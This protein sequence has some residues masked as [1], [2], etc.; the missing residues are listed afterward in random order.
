METEHCLDALFRVTPCI[1]ATYALHA[2]TVSIV[3]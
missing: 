1:V 2:S 3:C